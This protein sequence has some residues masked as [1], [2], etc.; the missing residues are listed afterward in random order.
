MPTSSVTTDRA[1]TPAGP[2]SQGIVANG[3]CST[4]GFGPQ[5]RTT[6]NS[7]LM[8]ILVQIDV[9]SVEGPS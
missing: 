8:D 9:V 7:D 4:A 5:V 2:Y 1:P 3:L 6:V